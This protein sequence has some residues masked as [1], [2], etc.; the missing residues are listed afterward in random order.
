MAKV[1]QAFGNWEKLNN[2]IGGLKTAMDETARES[3]QAHV[4]EGERFAVNAVKN[5]TLGWAPLNTRY[6]ARKRALGQSEKI[7]IRTASYFQAITSWVKGKE[8]AF[9]GVRRTVRTRDAAGRFNKGG[10]DN[11]VADI[12]NILEYGSPARGIPARPLW[13]PTA[14]HMAKWSKDKNVTREILKR[15]LTALFA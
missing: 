9:V 12:A 8:A 1:F 14:L 3:L 11:P 13:R 15:K 10:K 4:Q 6:L 5:Q 7:L 2:I